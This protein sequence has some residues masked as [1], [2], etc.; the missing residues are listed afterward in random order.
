M[1]EQAQLDQWE[2]HEG[3]PLFVSPALYAEIEKHIAETRPVVGYAE[4][5]GEQVPLLGEHP[6]EADAVAPMIC[7]REVY[8]TA[9]TPAPTAEERDNAITLAE[10]LGTE[11]HYADGVETGFVEG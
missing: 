3:E 7:G 6:W 8:N 11:Q 5:E 4:V 1:L 2:G 10:V 9:W